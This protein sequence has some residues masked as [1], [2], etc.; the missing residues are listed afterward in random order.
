MHLAKSVE[1]FFAKE[2]PWQNELLALR[3]ILAESALVEELKWGMPS[4]GE[5][6]Q[7]LIGIGAF[8]KWFCLWFHQGALLS[9]PYKVLIN[10]QEGKTQGMRQLRMSSMEDID[11]KLIAS[12]IEET[13]EHH[14]AGRKVVILPK[15]KT[16]S[17]NVAASLE[18]QTFMKKHKAISANFH[19]Y[20]KKQQEAFIEYISSAKQVKTKVSR[21]EKI[22]PILEAGKPL[23]ALWTKS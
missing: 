14:R 16:P 21:L 8:K 7:N 15:E 6:K 20:T 1:A 4:Y 5:D 23:A 13:I 11:A 2:S 10:A 12:Y 9:D 17:K 19:K 22:K 3:E 18:W